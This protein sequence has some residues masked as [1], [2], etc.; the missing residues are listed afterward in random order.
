MAD[1]EER[2]STLSASSLPSISTLVW[3]LAGLLPEDWFS[4]KEENMKEDG[5]IVIA[6]RLHPGKTVP[7]PL[8]PF[9]S[10]HETWETQMEE[11]ALGHWSVE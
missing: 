2:I 9:H 10:S 3:S 6:Y 8:Q 7:L 4:H 11:F 1:T 5:K